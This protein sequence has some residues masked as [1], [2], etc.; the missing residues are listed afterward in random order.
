MYDDPKRKVDAMSAEKAPIRQQIE[1]IDSVTRTWIE[2]DSV[3]GATTKALIVEVDFDTDP[4][5][6]SH[7]GDVLQNIWAVYAQREG[8]M[9]ISRLTIVPKDRPAQ[10]LLSTEK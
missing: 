10:D 5:A 8:A 1:K 4:H 6:K 7:R 2:F 9:G 3:G